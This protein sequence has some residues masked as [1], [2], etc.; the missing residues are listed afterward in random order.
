MVF[1]DEI[2]KEVGREYPDVK[3]YSYLVDAA[4]MFMVKDPRDSKSS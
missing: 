3:T 4:A 1:W 2:F